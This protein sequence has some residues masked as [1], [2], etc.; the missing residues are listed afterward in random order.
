MQSVTVHAYHTWVLSQVKKEEFNLIKKSILVIQTCPQQKISSKCNFR[1]FLNLGCD[2][3]C[4]FQDV[5][6][7]CNCFFLTFLSKRQAQ[8]SWYC[9]YIGIESW[10]RWLADIFSRLSKRADKSTLCFLTCANTIWSPYAW[11]AFWRWSF[12]TGNSLRTDDIMIIIHCAWAGRT[13]AKYH[14]FCKNHE[15]L[16]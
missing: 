1:S 7:G 4:L 10:D 2:F 14:H 6:S 5:M 3:N 12:W 8:E 11:L 15:F 16:F 9:F 13:Y